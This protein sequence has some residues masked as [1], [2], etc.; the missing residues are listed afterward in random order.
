MAARV[1]VREGTIRVGDRCQVGRA[2]GW[3]R[4][5]FDDQQRPIKEALLEGDLARARRLVNGGRHGHDRFA[6][7]YRAGDALLDDA[8]WSSVGRQEAA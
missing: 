6:A 7:A 8:V 4:A 2:V 5:M 1:L 3:V